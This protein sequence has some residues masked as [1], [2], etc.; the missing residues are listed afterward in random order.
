MSLLAMLVGIFLIYNSVAFSVLQ[1][2]E[3]IGVLR[4]L[5]VT[6]REVSRLIL[7]EAAIIGAIG[8]SLGRSSPRSRW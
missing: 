8:A 5:G 4:A 6:R 7:T 3:L 2:R 1:R